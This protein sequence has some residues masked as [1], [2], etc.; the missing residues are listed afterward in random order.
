LALVRATE[1]E[2]GCYVPEGQPEF[3]TE[4]AVLF[5]PFRWD[6]HSPWEWLVCTIGLS[7]V[8]QPASRVSRWER[9]KARLAGRRIGPAFRTFELCATFTEPD[10]WEEFHEA[11]DEGALGEYGVPPVIEHFALIAHDFA[12]WMQ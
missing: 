1:W 3:D 5:R 10:G 4:L 8:E 2:R 11:W 9:L 6:D 7:A 12:S